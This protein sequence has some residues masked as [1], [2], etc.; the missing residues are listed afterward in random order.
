MLME[1]VTISLM[2]RAGHLLGGSSWRR[3]ERDKE[4]LESMIETR[5]RRRWES[6][7]FFPFGYSQTLYQRLHTL[8]QEGKYV[9]DYTDEFYQ[10]VPMNDL[11]EID[12]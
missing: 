1:L 9:N 8:K 11:E 6:T 5:W 2:G 10:L 3:Q 12:E 4:K 7:F